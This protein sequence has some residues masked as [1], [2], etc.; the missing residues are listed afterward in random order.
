MHLVDY[1]DASAVKQVPTRNGFGE[2]LV[3][4]GRRDP[5]VMAICAD[6]A[7]ST[8]MEA[9]QE[10]VPRALRRDRR[11]RADARRDGRRSRLD[12]QG[13]VHRQLRHVQPGPLVGASAH[14]DGAQRDQRQDR[15]RARR[16]F[17][18]AR[19]RDPPGDRGHRDHAR[20]P[21]HDRGGAV[22]LGA[23]EAGHARRR[24][25]IRPD[26]PALRARRVGR[27]HHRR[28]AVRARQSADVPR[29]RRR[30]DRGLRHPGVRG[31][32]RGGAARPRTASSAGSSTTTPSSPWTSRRSSPR[33]ATAARW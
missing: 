25:E 1:R 29:G 26:L 22:R 27:H 6:L 10:G 32:R 8:R 14:H 33:R 2:G 18:R 9:V 21:E 17:G 24:G 19:R 15:G 5:N 28:D 16:R 11:G 20:D 31:A 7:E 3:E 13:A 23:D 12:R 4:A 30:G